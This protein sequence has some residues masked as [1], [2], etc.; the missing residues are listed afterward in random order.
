MFEG[1]I[2]FMPSKAL[3]F[4]IAFVLLIAIFVFMIEIF[5][6]ISAKNDLNT[7]CRKALL[8]MEIDSG[9]TSIVRDELITNL[10]GK[11][12]ESVVVQGTENAKFGQDI[13]LLVEAEYI[14]SK[15][16]S[17]LARENITQK[18]VYNKTTIARKV[19]N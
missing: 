19:V 14:Y 5:L 16:R 4:G 12:F 2:I 18:M 6:P 3:I 10:Y 11:G 8:K 17:I 9:L 13:T 15:L 7:I 1:G